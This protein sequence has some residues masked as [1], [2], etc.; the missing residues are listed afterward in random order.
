MGDEVT[1]ANS[2]DLGEDKTSSEARPEG[3]DFSVAL[4]DGHVVWFRDL[5]YG[6]RL[7]LSR[8]SQQMR[9]KLDEIDGGQLSDREKLEARQKI[10][11]VNN[12][13]MWDA[14]DSTMVFPDDIDLVMD[15]MISGEIDIDWATQALGRGE[16]DTPDVDD[17]AEEVKP[18][19][20]P[21]RRANVK[22]TQ[23]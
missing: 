16:A 6:Q 14:I 20:K 1:V 22:R 18:A 12:K 11:T 3:A 9:K 19:A 7:M 13:R 15:A 21:S 5:S 2:G 23:L 17:D 8:S 10:V 4:P